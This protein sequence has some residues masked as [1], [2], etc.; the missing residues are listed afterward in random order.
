MELH[1]SDERYP[2]NGKD[3]ILLAFLNPYLYRYSVAISHVG[4]TKYESCRDLSFFLTSCDRFILYIF[5]CISICRRDFVA[6]CFDHSTGTHPVVKAETW[7]YP[8][9][10]RRTRPFPVACWV[11]VDCQLFNPSSGVSPRLRLVVAIAA[12]FIFIYWALRRLPEREN[13]GRLHQ[14][15]HPLFLELIVFFSVLT[16]IVEVDSRWFPL[17][18]IITALSFMLA[19]RSLR[20]ET[21]RIRFYSLLFY[22][23]SAVQV[24]MIPGIVAEMNGNTPWYVNLGIID[25]VVIVLQFIYILLIHKLPFLEDVTFPR[26]LASLTE[27]SNFI[28]RRKNPWINYP[29]FISVAIF[30]YQSFSRAILT[31][32]WVV[33]CFFIFISSVILKE[34]HFRYVAMTGLALALLRLVFYDMAKSNTLTRALVFIGVGVIMLVMNSI[35]NKYKDRF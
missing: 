18:W 11:L 29:L 25:T 34:N 6:H 2:R 5:P 30:L 14:Y 17:I 19:G 12:V 15:L 3:H 27:V 7:K 28:N 8:G 32:L 35:Y 20:G 10:K 22:W 21:S 23:A 33:E 31:L 13:S 26:L 1:E 16:V 9:G 4:E 24:A